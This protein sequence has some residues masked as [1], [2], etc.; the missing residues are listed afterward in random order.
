[1]KKKQMGSTITDPRTTEELIRL[2]L[3]EKDE[4]AAWEPVTVLHE[5]GSREVL[6]AAQR[7]CASSEAAE[8][9][10]GANLLG[11]LGTPEQP[12]ADERFDCLAKTIRSETD[13][14]VLQAIAVAF[15]HLNDPR[16]VELLLPLKAHPDDLVRWG[17]VHGIKGHSHP[18]AAEALIELCR[19]EDEEVRD[20]ATFAL[21]SEIDADSPEIREALWECLSDEYDE[22][23]AEAL[24]GLA[25]RK[26]P[27]I[28]EILLKELAAEYVEIQTIDAAV[29]FGDP[30]LLPALK[31]LK[32]HWP[33]DREDEEECLDNAIHSCRKSSEKSR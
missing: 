29:E 15:G 31:K 10:L 14:D 25:R 16:C 3:T 26:D 4:D 30:I 13:A 27:R 5:R 18:G 9:E 33:E 23:R 17:V 6:V 12:F 19:D 11:Q 7:L 20:W 28:A 21:G 24:T 1:M 22:V 2:A 8:R 32:K